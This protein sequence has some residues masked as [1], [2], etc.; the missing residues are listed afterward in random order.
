MKVLCL[1][2]PL[3][4]LLFGCGSVEAPKPA[5]FTVA[6]FNVGFCKDPSDVVRWNAR[7]NLI[8]PLVEFHGFDIVGMRSRGAFR[9][10][11]LPRSPTN[12]PSQGRLSAT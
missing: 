5:E 9:L 8:M 2:S 1:I 4:L 6:S 11:I 7:K 12:T 3:F 10:T